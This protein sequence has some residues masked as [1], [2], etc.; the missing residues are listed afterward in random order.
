MFRAPFG[1][2]LIGGASNASGALH[3]FVEFGQKMMVYVDTA[4]SCGHLVSSVKG[5]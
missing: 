1:E 4:C 5:F 3:V 2:A